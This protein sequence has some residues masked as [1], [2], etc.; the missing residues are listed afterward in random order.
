MSGWGDVKPGDR[1]TFPDEDVH[2]VVE[3]V[4]LDDDGD[5][6]A[7]VIEMDNGWAVVDLSKCDPPERIG[8]H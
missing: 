6:A 5:P 7:L 8:V 3:A 1:L 2:G 4:M